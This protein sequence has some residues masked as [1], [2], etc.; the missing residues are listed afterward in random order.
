MK[1]ASYL[2]LAVLASLLLSSCSTGQPSVFHTDSSS[3]MSTTAADSAR[4]PWDY[5]IIKGTVGDLIGGD[6]TVLPDNQLLPNDGNYATGQSVWTLQYMYAE[7][8]TA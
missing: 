2:L 4:V 3:S 8:T 1:I 7:M 6:M 5:K